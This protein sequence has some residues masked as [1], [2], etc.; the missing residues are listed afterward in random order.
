MRLANLLPIG[1]VAGLALAVNVAPVAAQET[2]GVKGLFTLKGEIPKLEP[3]TVNKDV[4]V[5]AKKPVPNQTVVVD[6]ATK[7]LANVFVW[8]K[9][10]DEDDI[11]ESLQKP[12]EEKVVL[13][14]KNCVFL[15]H[16]LIVRTGQSLVALNGDP[17]SHNVRATLLRNGTFNDSIAPNDR[18]GVSREMSKAEIQPMPIQCD[19]HPWMQ[20]HMLVVD[21]PYAA[22]SDAKGQFTIEGL[23]EGKYDF[24]VWQESTGYIRKNID[25]LENVEVKAGETIDLGKIPVELD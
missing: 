22:L 8:I 15:P 4:A 6:P 18:E 12:K 1:L 3:P 19:I 25:V 16:C 11:P 17:V 14:Q 7:G 9:R 20:A 10:F 23:P 2:G 5:C 21:S 24:A 13:D